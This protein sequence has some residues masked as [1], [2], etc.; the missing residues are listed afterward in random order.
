MRW[1]LWQSQKSLGGHL[2][3]IKRVLVFACFDSLGMRSAVVNFGQFAVSSA[4][5]QCRRLSRPSSAQW[6]GVVQGEGNPA[7]PIRSI[8]PGVIGAA[9]YDRVAGFEMNFR[10][11]EHQRDLAFQDQAEVERLGPLHVRMRRLG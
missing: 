10:G 4:T 11:I 1:H 3:F 7:R 8:T 6:N 9:L 2:I 5:R